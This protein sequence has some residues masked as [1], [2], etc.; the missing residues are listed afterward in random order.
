MQD[1]TVR[2]AEKFLLEYQHSSL[3]HASVGKNAQVRL[4]DHNGYQFKDLQEREF[5]WIFCTA[6]V[7]RDDLVGATI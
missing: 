6:T 5:R 2:V 4:I 1:C 3:S 7:Y